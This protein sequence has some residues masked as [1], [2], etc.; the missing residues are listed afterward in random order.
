MLTEQDLKLAAPQLLTGD[1]MVCLDADDRPTVSEDGSDLQI[2]QLL[3]QEDN[4][5]EYYWTGSAWAQVTFAQKLDLNTQ[6]LR[7]IRDL[8]TEE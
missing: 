4:G 6:L 3:I 5:H 7:D 2:G 1:P 8:L